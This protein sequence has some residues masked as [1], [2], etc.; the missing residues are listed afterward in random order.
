MTI[1]FHSKNNKD[2]N[3]IQFKSKLKRFNDFGFEVWEFVEPS[4]NV[5]NRIEFKDGDVNIITGP[6]TLFLKLENKIEN[7]FKPG[8]G[9]ANISLYTEL[10]KIDKEDK[11]ISFSYLLYFSNDFNDPTEFEITIS[12]E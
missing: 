2:D 12:E 11:K 6:S 1:N 3:I 7:I 10:L 4:Q 9:A 8:N 5:K